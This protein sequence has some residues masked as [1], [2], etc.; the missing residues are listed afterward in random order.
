MIIGSV[1]GYFS[2]CLMIM[3]LGVEGLR[4]LEGGHTG[5]LTLSDVIEF[6]QYENIESE[7]IKDQEYVNLSLILNFSAFYCFLIIG[8]TLAFMFRKRF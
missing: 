7:N 4:F 1:L 6:I 3:V 2:L 8:I 5:L